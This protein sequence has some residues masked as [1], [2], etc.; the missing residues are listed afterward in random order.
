MNI[1][2]TKELCQDF[3]GKARI[4]FAGTTEEP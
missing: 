4:G 3:M 2:E 1:F